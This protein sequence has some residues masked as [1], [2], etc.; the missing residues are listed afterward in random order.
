MV[1]T[2]WA[3]GDWT[4]DVEPDRFFV[5]DFLFPFAARILLKGGRTRRRPDDPDGFEL[6][7]LSEPYR[8]L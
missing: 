6:M 7:D 8:A 3:I 5:L 1:S 2:S 4:N